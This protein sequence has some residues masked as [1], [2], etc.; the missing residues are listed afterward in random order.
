MELTK[1]ERKFAELSAK[2]HRNIL[3]RNSQSIGWFGSILFGLGLLKILPLPISYNKLLLQ[4]GFFIMI[5]STLGFAMTVIGKL[6]VRI[7]ELEGRPP[8]SRPNK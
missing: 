3:Y 6:Y 1:Q 7:Q 5:L 2:R 8:E 4:I